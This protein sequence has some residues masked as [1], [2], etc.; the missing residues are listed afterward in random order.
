MKIIGHPISIQNGV[1]NR[2]K[3][4]DLTANPAV[5]AFGITAEFSFHLIYQTQSGR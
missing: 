5:K 4:Y 1:E 2:D 3:A